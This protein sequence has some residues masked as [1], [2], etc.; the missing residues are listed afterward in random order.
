MESVG[1][2]ALLTAGLRT[3]LARLE[4][5]PDDIAIQILHHAALL[6]PDDAQPPISTT[7]LFAGAVEVGKDLSDDRCYPA[8]LARALANNTALWTRYEHDV[9]PLF[10]SESAD[11]ALK[12]LE[13]KWFSRNVERM[14]RKAASD[15]PEAPFSDRLV[16]TMLT[17]RNG[18]LY[19]RI[20]IARV[21]VEVENLRR[22]PSEGG[23]APTL[24]S[25]V[26]A[27]LSSLKIAAMEQAHVCLVR[28]AQL[29]ESQAELRPR[30][31]LWALL[32]AGAGPSGKTHP[33]NPTAM[34]FE[35][36][37]KDASGPDLVELKPQPP[38]SVSE[39]ADPSNP[40]RLAEA[41]K[42]L[43]RDAYAKQREHFLNEKR[44][45][46]WVPPAPSCCTGP[47]MNSGSVRW[48]S[49][50]PT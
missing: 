27:Q 17:S 15:K 41:T 36:I 18:L 24:A 35:A 40:L 8:G 11:A 33:M 22:A 47:K 14:L 6:S 7:R 39:L 10:K 23:T 12:R 21:A 13:P 16:Q 44:P 25:E 5:T 20:P 2:D 37:K 34:L 31:I 50:I 19:G 46:S 48:G 1:S 26:E 28:A 3:A 42:R 32:E 29:R 9:L 43:L 4:I 49:V 38:Q 30:H 45:R